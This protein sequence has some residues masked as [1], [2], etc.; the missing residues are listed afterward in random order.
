MILV[1]TTALHNDFRSATG[2]A[3]ADPTLFS[4]CRRMEELIAAQEMMLD[5]IFIY[6]DRAVH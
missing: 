3:L 5:T 4:E 1:T 6:A 2:E